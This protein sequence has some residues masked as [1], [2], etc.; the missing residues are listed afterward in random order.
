MSWMK[1]FMRNRPEPAM[2]RI[3]GLIG[4]KYVVPTRSCTALV[5]SFEDCFIMALSVSSRGVATDPQPEAA[6]RAVP[7]L[8]LSVGH[9]A[10]VVP[11]SDQ[12]P[13]CTRVMA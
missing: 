1:S 9:T 6:F 12:S 8:S 13:A 7:Q 2:F 5:A 4:G 10:V 11:A 3:Q